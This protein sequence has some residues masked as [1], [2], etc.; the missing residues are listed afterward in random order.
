VESAGG[1][2]EIRSVP[3]RGTS[4]DVELPD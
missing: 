3:G 1:R 4:I 2:F